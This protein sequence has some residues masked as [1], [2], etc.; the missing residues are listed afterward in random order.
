MRV[1]CQ[2]D[3]IEI[4]GDY[5]PVPSIEATCSRC[6]HTTQSY[7]Q[8]EASIKRCLALMRQECPRQEKNFYVGDD[9]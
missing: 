6:G 8:S 5:A 7:G 1:L 9:D 3:H 2:I 4:E